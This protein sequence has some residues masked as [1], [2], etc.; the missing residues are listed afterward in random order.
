MNMNMARLTAADMPLFN[1]ITS[2]LFPGVEVP[3][4]DYGKVCVCVCARAR[5]RMCVHLIFCC[6]LVTKIFNSKKFLICHM[7]ACV[8]CISPQ[9]QQAIEE[10]L[11]AANLQVIDVTVKKIVQLYET[12][13]SRHAVMIVGQTGS[14]KSVTWRTLRNTLT[15]LSKENKDSQYQI[16]RVRSLSVCQSIIEIQKLKMLF[17]NSCTLLRHYSLF[18]LSLHLFLRIFP[19]TPRVCRWE[20]CMESITFLPMSGVMVCSQLSWEHSVQVTSRLTDWQANQ[21]DHQQ[22]DWLIDWLS[23]DWLANFLT[24]FWF[25]FQ[26]INLM[27]NGLCLML[28]WTHS[29]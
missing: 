20:S 22:T 3:D 29:G 18:L 26:M 24:F 16:V 13:N 27:R 11:K 15:R 9:M 5:V 1:G 12:K 28:Q 7:W 21:P 10:E 23:S 19:L 8:T 14:G 6:T 17:S 25:Y 4:L 2:D